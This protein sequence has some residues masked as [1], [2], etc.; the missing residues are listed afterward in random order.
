M[1]LT[2]NPLTDFDVAVALGALRNTNNNPYVGLQ[3]NAESHVIPASTTALTSLGQPHFFPAAATAVRIAAGGNAADD[4]SGNNARKVEITG[5]DINGDLATEVLETAGASASASSTKLW[6]RV[7][8]CLVN[9]VGVFGNKNLGNIAIET[10]G[11][12]HLFG[13]LAGEGRSQ[14]GAFAVPADHTGLFRSLT[15]NVESAKAVTFEIWARRNLNVITQPGVWSPHLLRH[16]ASTQPGI[17]PVPIRSQLVIPAWTDI[18]IT[19]ETVTGSTSL[20]SAAGEF[21]LIPNK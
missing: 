7:F 21:L 10:T 3:L 20:A 1:P 13:I 5:I 8:L 4:I 17:W 14:H 2:F 11:G 16:Y 9:E 18:Y 19:A 6:W 12:D 15:L